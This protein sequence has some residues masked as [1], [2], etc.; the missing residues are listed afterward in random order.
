VARFQPR[1]ARL[2]AT[3]TWSESGATLDTFSVMDDVGARQQDLK[4]NRQDVASNE[5]GPGVDLWVLGP[6]VAFEGGNS[7]H[8]GGP[9][10]RTVCAVLIAE[11]GRTVSAD[12]LVEEVWGEAATAGSRGTLQT[13]ISNLRAHLGDRLLTEGGGYRLDVA[14]DEVDAYRFEDAIAQ[15]RTV[16]ESQPAEAAQ[17]LGEALGLWRGH[18]YADVPGSVRLEVEA[19]RLEQ[20]R[21]G[22]KE[23]RVE[24]ELLMGR[25][26]E[27]L[28]E[29]EVLTAEY[30]LSER[31]RAQHMLALYRAGRQ[32][33]ALR[34]YQRT[35]LFLAEEMGVDP[36]PMLQGLEQR[37]LDHDPS[38]EP[39]T[40]PRVQTMTFLMTDI[41]D[42]T[43]LWELHPGEMPQVLERH[44]RVLAQTMEQ[45]GGRVFTHSGD[46]VSAAFRTVSEA[47]TAARS[48]QE[49]LGA[50]DWGVTELSV[51]MAVD[52]GEVESRADNFFGP[53]LNR[54][55]RILAS[56]HGGQVLLS[57]EAN[58]SLAADPSGGWQVRS[59]G[60][61]RFK[62]LGR[63]EHVFQLLAEGLPADFPPLRID[64]QPASLPL[65]GRSVRG[66][67]LRERVGAGDFGIV[68]RA[69]QPGVGREVAVKLIRPEFVNR[70]E[71]V[72]RF[73][74]EAH[75]VAQLEHPHIVPLYDYWRDP[76]GAYLVTRWLRGGS[77]REALERGPWNQEPAT[78]LLSQVSLALSYAHRRGVV[79]RDVKPANVLLDEDGNGYLADFGI[80]TRLLG[81]AERAGPVSSSPAYLAPEELRGEPL[82][83]RSDIYS[84]GLLTFELLSGTR[85]PMD[86]NIPS[87][88]S[89]R[90]GVPVVVD[91]VIAQASADDPA[92]RHET[93]EQFLDA[94]LVA[95][96]QPTPPEEVVDAALSPARNPYKGL[97]AFQSSDAADF[98]GRADVVDELLSAVSAKRLVAVVGPSGIGKSSV[99]RAG[100]IPKVQAGALDGEW[101]VTDLYPGSFPFDELAAALLRV[102]V[103]RPPNL[104][105]DLAADDRGVLRAVRE[106]LPA[107]ARLL[108]VIDQ[109]EELFTLTPDEETRRR[110]LEG[111]VTL[112][113]DERTPVTVVVTLRADFLDRPLRYQDFGDLL[114]ASTVMVT[115]PSPDELIEAIARPAENVRVGLESG[116]AAHIAGDVADQPG[117]LPLLQYSLTELFEGRSSNRLSLDGYQALGGVVGALGRRAEMLHEQLDLAG[118]E[119][120]RQVFLRLVTVDET[121]Q[122]TR[123][124][125]TRRELLTL[126]LVLTAV[127]QVLDRYGAHRLLTFDRHPVTRAPT[128]EVAHEALLSNWDRL[129]GWID[130]RREDLLVHRRLAAAVTEWEASD[131]GPS[132][133]L[134][135][136]RLEQFESL[137]ASTDLAIGGTER[138][139]IATSRVA[140]DEQRTK[141]YR[142]RRAIFAALGVAALVSLGAAG[143]AYTNQQRAEDAAAEAEMQRISAEQA[144]EQ[145]RV[146]AAEAEANAEL[147]RSRELAAA[148]IN[149]LD[150]DPELSV[151][152]AIQA[153]EVSGG[154]VPIESV[155]ALHEALFNDRIT[156]AHPWPEERAEDG[157]FSRISGDGRYLAITGLANYLE[158]WDLENDRQV[159]SVEYPPDGFVV[160]DGLYFSRDGS[161]LIAGV[162]R[163]GT[164]D[165]PAATPDGKLPGIYIWDVATGD[166]VRFIDVGL[167]GGSIIGFAKDAE[168]ALV[169]AAAVAESGGCDWEATPRLRLVDLANGMAIQRE[170]LAPENYPVISAD[171]RYLARGDDFTNTQVLD[172]DTGRVVFDKPPNAFNQIIKGPNALS[173]D[174]GL[175]L[176]GAR[177]LQVWNVAD[178][179]LVTQ[180]DQNTVLNIGGAWFGDDASVVYAI[181][182]DGVLRGWSATTGEPIMAVRTGDNFTDASVTADGT[183]AAVSLPDRVGIFDLSASFQAELGAIEVCPGL[184]RTHSL[185]VAEGYGAV[186]MVCDGSEDSTG[187]VF[188]LANA[189]VVAE[190]SDLS[191]QVV[192]LSPDGR[193][194]AAFGVPSS[195]L[196]GVHLRDVASGESAVALDGLCSGSNAADRRWPGCADPLTAGFGLEPFHMSFSPDGS[197]L[198]IG[199]YG[200]WGVWDAVSGEVLHAELGY[201]WGLAFNEASDRLAVAVDD[202]LRTLD[203][204]TW[205]AQAKT[206]TPP[207]IWW[208]YNFSPEGDRLFGVGPDFLNIGVTDLDS[209]ETT[210]LVPVPHQSETKNLDLSNDG[211]LI[212]SAGADGFVRVWDSANGDLVYEVSLGETQVQNVE[213]IDDDRHLVVTPQ[214]GPVLIL[215]MDLDELLQVG[216]DRLTR[217][218]SEAECEK[219]DLDPCPALADLVGS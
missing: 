87:V 60:E 148:A 67:E 68:Y 32:T 194:L 213:F 202:S 89:L 149:V 205:K 190:I 142:R 72:R 48:G 169:R 154:A 77:L 126:P 6:V 164:P 178:G 121:S 42:S 155:S 93:P 132:Y 18:T 197:K 17:L 174:G 54:C 3:A 44:D 94:L 180:F 162:S 209:E 25:H 144:A 55:A 160:G 74:S 152:L 188:D 206:T 64:R 112:A 7:V 109:F 95:L 117:A 86:G 31:F 47:V 215:T 2:W 73:E 201:A 103:R 151:L 91:E 123:R 158:V 136:G 204:T 170:D 66:Y 207:A 51:R 141:R 16:L 9:R 63:P 102:A 122:D 108:L 105:D 75:L 191:G 182:R 216:R 214:E 52:T 65:P 125:V 81:G 116:L 4:S 203:T 120:A 193:R 101:L 119:A 59:L 56:G 84:L 183:Q 114:A 92:D 133:L 98:Y 185:S 212:A 1:V 61:H 106:L 50:A 217:G 128:V 176:T 113:R 192:A 198:A 82:S 15:A 100:L 35:R 150:D 40:T 111:L 208:P 110:F 28:P 143:V 157:G 115:A 199:G 90:P 69:Y 34:A 20:L 134:G 5:Y 219:Y 24:A 189:E 200:E 45:A 76:D 99:V 124:R 26:A 107:G 163:T 172:L 27:L 22:A 181:G 129:R 135:G 138:E 70:A 58:A 145:E 62:G 57:E 38:L 173:S 21:L 127:E 131:R 161:T 137:A 210:N 147:A 140:E 130:E 23:D 211:S 195:E 13:H 177:P 46:G 187:F 78:R 184:V 71:F 153:A 96:G 10:P 85:P 43:L 179:T 186:Q 168:L 83:A 19:R 39:E 97:Q 171:G 146:A 79:H 175:L 30:P 53:P 88:A 196:A 12:V 29:L 11:A 159:W 37:I 33:E 104:V 8:L 139:F 80:A 41:V 166:V 14:R 218:F 49:A 118:Q 165:R 36:S 167:C 156:Y